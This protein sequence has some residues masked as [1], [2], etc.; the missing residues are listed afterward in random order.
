[1]INIK[2][3]LKAQQVNWLKVFFKNIETLPVE[4]IKTHLKM[5]LEHTLKSN[6]NYNKPPV[7]LPSV[8]NNIFCSWF[9]FK[10]EP[11]TI[12]EIKREVI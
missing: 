6:S 3:Y 11:T 5:S 7:T 12:D 9:S 8:Y 4:H 1:M 10:L 2:H